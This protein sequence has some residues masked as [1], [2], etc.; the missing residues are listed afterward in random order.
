[1]QFGCY[2]CFDRAASQSN[3]A[4]GPSLLDDIRPSANHRRQDQSCGPADADP[5]THQEQ[6]RVGSVRARLLRQWSLRVAPRTSERTPTHAQKRARVLSLGVVS[7]A[8]DVSDDEEGYQRSLAVVGP[9]SRVKERLSAPLASSVVGLSIVCSSLE[10]PSEKG[11][12][13]AGRD[14]SGPCCSMARGRRL[15]ECAR[16]V[17]AQGHCAAVCLHLNPDS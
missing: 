8:A 9:P 6:V 7:V 16:C 15:T 14:L 2:T 17:S 11:V 4:D 3:P 13:A 1:M 12:Y 10:Q 5:R